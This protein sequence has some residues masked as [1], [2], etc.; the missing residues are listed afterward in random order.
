V[1]MKKVCKMPFLAVSGRLIPVRELK[2]LQSVDNYK[3]LGGNALAQGIF[4]I[5]TKGGWS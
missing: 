3:V 1:R 5:H 4:S 2:S